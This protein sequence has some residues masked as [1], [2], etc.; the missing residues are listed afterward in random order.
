MLMR[1]TQPV[2]LWLHG[3]SAWV[4]PVRTPVKR[5]VFVCAGNI[6]R[7][8][9]GEYLAKRA[10]VA[11][12]SMGLRATAGSPAN[13]Q[14][15]RHALR[16]GL[17]MTAHRARPLV[18]EQLEDTDLILAFERWQALEIQTALTGRRSTIRLLGGFLGFGH[19]HLHDPYGLSDDYFSRCFAAIEQGVI[20]LLQQTDTEKD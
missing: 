14:A 16:H 11:S 10:G 17:D 12:C 7:S 8:P 15:I 9:F 3:E 2:A 6:C 19:Y 4:S 5:L 18:P 1:W 13:P 20:A